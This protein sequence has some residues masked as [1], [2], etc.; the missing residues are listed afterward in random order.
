M[1]KFWGWLK[2][3]FKYFASSAK[4]MIVNI[5]KKLKVFYSSWR[6]WV[7]TLCF[8]LAVVFICLW[9]V[10]PWCKIVGMLSLTIA[11]GFL[12]WYETLFYFN[13]INIIELQKREI[14]EGLANQFDKQE[15]LELKTPFN[16]KDE[17]I[18][19]NQIKHYRNVMIAC[20]VIFAVSLLIL[21]LILF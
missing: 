16:E 17:T 10:A 5:L 15:Y 2:D 14:L 8:I 19:K 1:K 21:I 9:G 12:G 20:W 3:T 6:N 13:F 4:N 11:L 7:M 18:I